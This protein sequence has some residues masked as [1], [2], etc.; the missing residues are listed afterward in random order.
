[1][2]RIMAYNCCMGK[3]FVAAQHGIHMEC[4]T[5]G[6]SVQRTLYKIFSNCTAKTLRGGGYFHNY[7]SYMGRCHCEGYGFQPVQSRSKRVLFQNRVSLGNQGL[8]LGKSGI[9]LG[10]LVSS[11]SR[12]GL[13]NAAEYGL[14]VG[15]GVIVT[16]T[17]PHPKIYRVSFPQGQDQCYYRLK[18]LCVL[19]K[20]LTP[21]RK[22]FCYTKITSIQKFWDH[23]SNCL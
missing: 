11:Q 5:S 21:S 1:M 23:R 20:E 22:L 2:Y 14:V 15:K 17:H 13:Q 4:T 7:R 8:A 10:F 3:T 9:K 16:A 6:S 12:I 18:M 19:R